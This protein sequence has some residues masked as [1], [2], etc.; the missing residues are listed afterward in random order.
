MRPPW[1]EGC[2]SVRKVTDGNGFC[3]GRYFFA[4]QRKVCTKRVIHSRKEYFSGVDKLFHRSYLQIIADISA[5][6]GKSV[7]TVDNFLTA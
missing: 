7:G 3:F 2:R 4:K 1:R 6:V 5:I